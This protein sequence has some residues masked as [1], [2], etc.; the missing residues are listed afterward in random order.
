M[1]QS[2]TTNVVPGV[3][4]GRHRTPPEQKPGSPIARHGGIAVRPRQGHAVRASCRSLRSCSCCRAQTK[5]P[6]ARLWSEPQ[7]S[8]RSFDS[9]CGKRGDLLHGLGHKKPPFA[10]HP[11]RNRLRLDFKH[12]ITPA[13]FQRCSRLQCGFS[14]NVARYD[15]AARLVHGRYQGLSC[16]TI[17]AIRCAGVLLAIITRAYN[18]SR[19]QTPE[20]LAATSGRLQATAQCGCLIVEALTQPAFQF[21]LFRSRNIVESHSGVPLCIH[22]NH[23]AADV[24]SLPAGR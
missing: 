22:P 4:L 12:A 5:E 24:E 14:P 17:C 9:G 13:D 10:H 23:H 1:H 20:R 3:A 21:R 18:K 15:K 16:T 19:G 11:D 2:A 7:L 8:P 6:S